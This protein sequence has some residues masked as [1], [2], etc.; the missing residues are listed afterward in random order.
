[1]RSPTSAVHCVVV[2]GAVVRGTDVESLSF[3][4]G[5][6]MQLLAEG[7]RTCSALTVHRS[8]LLAGA[9]GAGAHHHESSTELIYVISG[10]LRLLVDDQVVAA[11]AGD[12]AVIPPGIT[13]AFEAGDG[14]ADLIDIVTPGIERFDMFREIAEAANAGRRPQTPLDEQTRYDTYADQS[15][16]WDAVRRNA[17]TS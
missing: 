15:P 16:A 8:L 12:F 4:G 11:E 5:S 13:H 17:R 3:P 6:V 9:D 10:S 14:G 1:M 2:R 7:A